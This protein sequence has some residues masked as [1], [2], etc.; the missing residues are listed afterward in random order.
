MSAAAC[1]V[2][3]Y[4]QVLLFTAFLDC[5]LLLVPA[6]FISMLRPIYT[7]F[8]FDAVVQHAFPV[9][10]NQVLQSVQWLLN[11]CKSGWPRA[12]FSY[13]STEGIWDDWGTLELHFD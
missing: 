12:S 11:I 2:G 9:L 3:Y 13:I 10:H 4:T 8:D 6:K 1:L 7:L 5:R